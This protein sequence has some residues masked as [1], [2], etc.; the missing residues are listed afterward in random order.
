MDQSND[1]AVALTSHLYVYLF[2]SCRQ[3]MLADGRTGLGATQAL[4][5]LLCSR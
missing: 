3:V 4:K 2:S 1:Y 5:C